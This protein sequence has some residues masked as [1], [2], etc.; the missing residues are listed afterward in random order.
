MESGEEY[1]EGDI[2]IMEKD[3]FYIWGKW[4]QNITAPLIMEFDTPGKIKKLALGVSFAVMID[5]Q[6][7]VWSWGY[8]V[9]GCL[10]LGI[11][12]KQA[13]IPERIQIQVPDDVVFE[14]V[15]IGDNHVIAMASNGFVFTW[16]SNK[17]FQCGQGH[18][19]N[20]PNFWSPEQ[21]EFPNGVFAS[22]IFAS[23]NSSYIITESFGVYS[24]GQ[25]DVGQ[26]GLSSLVDVDHPKQVE[27]FKN[28]PVETLI[29]RGSQV[30]AIPKL[31]EEDSELNS[32]QEIDSQELAEI[33]KQ[34]EEDAKLG[35]GTS[36]AVIN[37][38]AS[39]DVSKMSKSS[40]ARS[41][42]KSVAK[43][44]RSK[45]SRATSKRG[46]ADD[47]LALNL[48]P[49]LTELYKVHSRLKE[50]DSTVDE[51]QENY[52]A[53]GKKRIGWFELIMQE[54]NAAREQAFVFFSTL[55][56]PD[57]DKEVE[58]FKKML[59]DLMQDSI[60]LRSIQ[61]TSLAMNRYKKKLE[62]QNYV[63]LADFIE[64]ISK[65]KPP[66]EQLRYASL[67]HCKK[68]TSKIMEKRGQFSDLSMGMS[69]FSAYTLK[70]VL[71]SLYCQAQLWTAFSN[72]VAEV[73]K[74][75]RTLEKKEVYNKMVE[76]LWRIYQ[77]IQTSSLDKVITN[78]QMPKTEKNLNE[79]LIDIVTKSERRIE[80]GELDLDRFKT[81]GQKKFDDVMKKMF[82]LMVENVELRKL[83]NV[84]HRRMLGVEE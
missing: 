47:A 46:R 24:W 67:Y 64:G 78:G 13:K 32:S 11:D 40:K 50:I 57:D 8:N 20:Q 65:I 58:K 56:S 10:G 6:G 1:M 82:E 83:L 18:E 4:S 53:K 68:I 7:H 43:S 42:A 3:P 70:F 76:T 28:K 55:Y 21:V 22:Q 36:A 41:V 77:K 73:T 26:L 30:L 62:V 84:A 80:R 59:A 25:N 54:L 34:E 74:I 35:G 51:V 27:T 2:Q 12:R 49:V 79:Y 75:E 16:G 44:T 81:K 31:P 48:K 69:H 52:E 63:N 38:I 23:G 9:E 17:N 15:V 37:Q 60:S 33:K 66:E 14:D 29:F 45:F 61:I 19:K 72:M 71:D 39:Q 5:V